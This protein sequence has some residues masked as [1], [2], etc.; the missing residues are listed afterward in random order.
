LNLDGPRTQSNDY[1]RN[2]GDGDHFWSSQVSSHG[3]T[4]VLV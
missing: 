3:T 2:R 4:S 1:R